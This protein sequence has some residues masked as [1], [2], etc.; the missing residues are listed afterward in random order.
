V[1]AQIETLRRVSADY[2]AIGVHNQE[3]EGSGEG[4]V[5][6]VLEFDTHHSIRAMLP[7][8]IVRVAL[9]AAENKRNLG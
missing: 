4:F 6:D 7:G 8:K 1:G 3:D 5:L 9:R 2:T